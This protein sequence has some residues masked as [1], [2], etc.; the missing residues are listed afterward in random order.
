MSLIY[1]LFS[2]TLHRES[3]VTFPLGV[4][5][6]ASYNQI[7]QRVVTSNPL[8]LFS[9]SLK[10]YKGQSLFNPSCEICMHADLM[11]AYKVHF[12]KKVLC[13]IGT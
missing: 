8:L 13:Q 9:Q 12:K 10:H 5:F 7:T 3:V 2:R 11:K 4:Y 1:V 6:L